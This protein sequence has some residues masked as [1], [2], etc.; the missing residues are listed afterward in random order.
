M[1]TSSRIA[2]LAIFSVILFSCRV[3]EPISTLAPSNNK[4]YQV[5]YLFEHDGCKVYRFNDY[6]RYVYFTNCTGEVTCIEKDSTE[7]RILN[8]IKTSPVK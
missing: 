4:T 6:G 1:N 2:L 8:T 5:D 7:N 3:M